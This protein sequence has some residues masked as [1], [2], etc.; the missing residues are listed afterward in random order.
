MDWSIFF[1]RFLGIYL[2]IIVGIWL[3]RKE[4]FEA[5]VKDVISST[6][7]FALTG[8]VHIIVGLAIALLHPIWSANWQGLIT[9]I[10]Y[11]SIAQG[12][13]RLAFPIQARQNILKSL[14]K[15]YW[16]WIAVAGSIGIILTY[17]GYTH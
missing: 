2:L 15:G 6:G 7:M 16:I 9:L 8:A 1:A 17:N 14:D 13:L 4:S 11:T 12:I 3:L 10:G 5:G